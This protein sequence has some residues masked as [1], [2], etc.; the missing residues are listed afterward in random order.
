[1]TQHKVKVVEKWFWLISE[2]LGSF[3]WNNILIQLPTLT[4]NKASL[5]FSGAWGGKA[6]SRGQVLLVRSS[7]TSSS[8]RQC[9]GGGRSGLFSLCNSSY[10]L[11]CPL[12]PPRV[13]PKEAD[14][15]DLLVLLA[16][17]HPPPTKWYSWQVFTWGLVEGKDCAPCTCQQSTVFK[18]PLGVWDYTPRVPTRIARLYHKYHKPGLDIGTCT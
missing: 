3:L 2:K 5:K 13:V 17:A 16:Q 9:D 11:W 15:R 7:T 12:W 14:S 10:S 6:M 8:R 1:M 18:A 4:K